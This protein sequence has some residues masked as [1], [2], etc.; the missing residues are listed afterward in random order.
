MISSIAGQLSHV[1]DGQ[2]SLRVGAMEFTLLVPASDNESLASM[3]GTDVIFHTLV[4]LEGDPNRGNL[5]P[6]MIGFLRKADR[7]F[8]ELFTT[9]KGIGP[10]TALR[11]FSEPIGTIA[12]AIESK[13]AR[14]LQKLKGIGK[15]TAELIVAELSG[16]VGAYATG[17][18]SDALAPVRKKNNAEE[19]AIMT[20]VALGD[21]RQDAEI[22]LEKARA[23]NAAL[24]TTQQF[25]SEML[26]L[27]SAR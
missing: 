1:E 3:T 26:R 16:K 22:L 7:A 6:R 27:R 17:P 20:L 15:R 10:K 25:V 21:R 8:F 4:Y 13:D 24:Q 2:I 19:D 9:V 23:T 12:S 18:V 5:E 14:T 11:A